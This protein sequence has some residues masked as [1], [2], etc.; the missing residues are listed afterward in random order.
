MKPVMIVLS[1][2]LALGIWG[3]KYKHSQ[4]SSEKVSKDL[5][6]SFKK[7]DQEAVDLTMRDRWLAER[8]D[9]ALSELE[10]H[11]GI[12]TPV[13]D[14]GKATNDIPD[15]YKPGFREIKSEFYVPYP[16]LSSESN[17]PTQYEAYVYSESLT[18]RINMEIRIRQPFHF[19]TDK[20]VEYLTQRMKRLEKYIDESKDVNTPAEMQSSA[21]KPK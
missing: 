6:D 1:T 12:E 3:C 8:L 15:S 10:K 16:I 11:Y 13:L 9:A 18:A 20:Y 5:V 21:G 17:L 4:P 19:R 7:L 2:F 14:F